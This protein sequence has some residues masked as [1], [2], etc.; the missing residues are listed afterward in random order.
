[1]ELQISRVIGRL[2]RIERTLNW[3]TRRSAEMPPSPVESA[4]PAVTAP[5]VS[6]V[7][8]TLLTKPPIVQPTAEK[9]ASPASEEPTSL[10]RTIGGKWSLWVGSLTVFL[11]IAF[12]LAYVW[13]YLSEADRFGLSVAI[14]LVF[15][16][17][18]IFFKKRVDKW[19]GEGL[20]GA[21]LAILYLSFWVGFAQFHLLSFLLGFSL[22]VVICV[23]G[24]M[25]SIIYDAQSLSVLAMIGGFLAPAIMEQKGAGPSTANQFLAYIAL[26]NAGLL[27]V[28][29]FK[30]WR[31]LTW[32]CFIA[33]IMVLGGWWVNSYQP[34][35]HWLLFGYLSVYFFLFMGAACFYSIFHREQ[36]D[37]ENILLLMVDAFVYSIVAEILIHRELVHFPAAFILGLALFFAF[38]MALTHR[39]L[40]ENKTLAYSFGALSILYLT[41]AIPIQ[42]KQQAIGIGWTVEAAALITAALLFNNR[43]LLWSGEIVWVAALLDIVYIEMIHFQVTHILILN[44]KALPI[45][46]FMAANAWLGYY[47][48]RDHINSA[49]NWCELFPIVA[50][51]AGGIVIVQ[52]I[53]QTYN[54]HLVT[55]SLPRQSLAAYL[56]IVLLAIYCAGVWAVGIRSKITEMRYTAFVILWVAMAWAIFQGR[57]ETPMHAWPFLN[58]RWLAFLVGAGLFGVLPRFYRAEIVGV[59]ENERHQVQ[60]MG[61]VSL[62]I[63][64]WGT[65]QET[66]EAFRYAA[67]TFGTSWYRAAQMGISLV[68]TVFGVTM[69]TGGVLKRYR[70]IRL[71]G[72]ALLGLTILKAFLY[73]LSFVNTP[74]RILTFAGLGISLIGISWL[75]SRY[76]V[77]VETGKE[78][79]SK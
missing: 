60:T 50:T 23:A 20:L 39:Y 12:F 53:Y 8:S 16:G 10:E 24:I 13:R 18:G 47:S 9:A 37:A 57:A 28:S 76:G 66:F 63:L 4:K 77:G 48:R 79:T 43:R 65:T 58:V 38:A 33:T 52:A 26:L 40:N 14:G 5:P 54:W 17:A 25:F 49:E 70:P 74:Y 30:R 2:D 41:I 27:A 51:V 11:A 6:Q 69:L 19:F 32:L 36:M 3:P 42:L 1:M 22:L 45:L 62:F 71:A 46:L 61:L 34:S 7:S 31:G 15:L 55:A 21:G 75:Y 35:E 56:S 72:L 67:G 78:Q 64:L 68:W 44:E 29:R 59:S 73:D